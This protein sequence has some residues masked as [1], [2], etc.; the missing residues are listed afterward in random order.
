MQNFM[1]KKAVPF[2]ILLSFVVI[3]GQ[4]LLSYARLNVG[5]LQIARLTNKPGIQ[6]EE[7]TESP[8][9]F[10]QQAAL[11]PG[12]R[13]AAWRGLAFTSIL[14]GDLEQAVLAWQESQT[15]MTELLHFG[16]KKAKEG[17]HDE[18][19]HWFQV[20]AELDL[21]SA[22]T[23]LAEQL[24]KLGNHAGAIEV[25][26]NSLAT[27]PKNEQRHDW[28]LGLS[29][30]F[31]SNQEW[32][33]AAEVSKKAL[34]EFPNDPQLLTSLGSA[35]LGQDADFETIS[36]VL[37]QAISFDENYAEAYTTMA[38]LMARENRDEEAFEYFGHAIERDPSV[39]WWHVAHA[40]MA[41]RLGNLGV[42]RT[43]LFKSIELFPDYAP[44]YYELAWIFKLTDDPIQ[45][46]IAIEQALNLHKTP[47]L[48]YYVRAGDIYSWSNQIDQARSSYQHA[49][50]LAPE[51]ERVIRGLESL[52][53]AP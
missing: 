51:D 23:P 25:W 42:A 48:N 36:S 47:P 5:Y 45:A 8:E 40:N 44:S 2:L 11:F 13:H 35:L 24:Y 10:F 19:L 41:R 4:S 21:A 29:R 16:E 15:P 6:P 43:L 27:Y 3:Q 50:E 53:R 39:K 33:L 26:Q 30:S 49:A 14:Q 17:R 34:N 20:A 31:R 32:D 38:R 1:S 18:A 37:Q 28:W 22:A 7:S 46:Q 52:K 12:T 9:H